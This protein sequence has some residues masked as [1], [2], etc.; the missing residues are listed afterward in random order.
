MIFP[1]F[2]SN[3]HASFHLWWKDIL[4]KH[5]NVSEYYENDCRL[6]DTH[7][8][9]RVQFNNDSL[10]ASHKFPK[11]YSFY[12][13]ILNAQMFEKYDSPNRQEKWMVAPFSEFYGKVWVSFCVNI[14]NRWTLREFILYPAERTQILLKNCTRDFQNSPPL[15]RSDVFMSQ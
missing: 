12:Y 7:L 1:N 5:Q 6:H 14:G 13:H 11:F 2:L 3:N 8:K 15:E 9:N 4:V 10:A